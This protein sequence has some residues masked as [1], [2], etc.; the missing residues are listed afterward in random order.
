[1]TTAI[2][3]IP[4]W[5]LKLPDLD[6][7]E[8]KPGVYLVGQPKMRDGKIVGLANYYGTLAL[9]EMSLM[10]KPTTDAPE[11]FNVKG[12]INVAVGRNK[13]GVI[14][15]YVFTDQDGKEAKNETGMTDAELLRTIQHGPV[16]SMGYHLDPRLADANAMLETALGVQQPTCPKC[17]SEAWSESRGNCVR[18]GYRRPHSSATG[19]DPLDNPTEPQT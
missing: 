16:L 19:I 5:M 9:I 18:C 4:D 14:D 6:G 12:C 17:F 11:R 2:A 1:M 8:V 10:V 7:F 3:G 15:R 13:D